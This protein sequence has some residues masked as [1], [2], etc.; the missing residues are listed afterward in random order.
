MSIIFASEGRSDP[1]ADAPTISSVNNDD[2]TVGTCVAGGWTSGWSLTISGALQAGQEYYVQYRNGSSPGSGSW[3]FHE[4]T[5]STTL[6]DFEDAQVSTDGP[7]AS[8]TRYVTMRAYVVP[9]GGDIGD[10]CSGPTTSSEISETGDSC[11]A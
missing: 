1:C 4:R 3:T 5:T 6:S 10:A 9:T 11:F 8:G 2:S 7:G